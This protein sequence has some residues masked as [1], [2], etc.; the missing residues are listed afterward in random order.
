MDSFL[1]FLANLLLPAYTVKQAIFIEAKFAIKQ[2][3]QKYHS[4]TNLFSLHLISPENLDF[5]P[6]IDSLDFILQS[7]LLAKVVASK[8]KK[9][10]HYQIDC[11]EFIFIISESHFNSLYEILSDTKQPKNLFAVRLL[12]NI[13]KIF[14]S[15][16]T[17]IGSLNDTDLSSFVLEL[18]KNSMIT[19]D[20]LRAVIVELESSGNRIY[21]FLPGVIKDSLKD[22]VA[23][24]LKLNRYWIE[25]SLF[26]SQLN[27]YT[28]LISGKLTSS[29]FSIHQSL[30]F[31]YY[32][33]VVSKKKF[34][35]QLLKVSDYGKLQLALSKGKSKD[36][37]NVIDFLTEGELRIIEKSS[38]KRN[39]RNLMIE[40]KF[41]KTTE[42]AFITSAYSLIKLFIELDDEVQKTGL[43][44]L[45][46]NFD[47][48][49]I[50]NWILWEM[51]LVSFVAVLKTLKQKNLKLILDNLPAISKSVLRDFIDGK[52]KFKNISGD[53]K[54][55]DA[56]IMLKVNL[57]FLKEVG[58]TD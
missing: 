19:E 18:I 6:Y 46:Q 9:R 40:S 26:I 35:K 36:W 54:N 13:D 14:P 11:F 3:L 51:G 23:T 57:I 28:L 24:G 42:L 29:F 32:S 31:L 10:I 15:F 58:L 20:M 56:V 21:S 45:V 38:S 44:D 5:N 25:Q 27:S 52:I 17:I 34:S 2:F 37:I 33:S 30:L 43:D 41:Q 1:L 7:K 12:S 50:Y 39:F 8:E 53:K 4:E 47:L 55:S 48:R 49:Y 16:A 22:E